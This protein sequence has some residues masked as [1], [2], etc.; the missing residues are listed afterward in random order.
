MSYTLACGDVMP[1]CPMTFTHQSQEELLGAVATHAAS[2][3]GIHEIT[4]SV[5]QAVTAAIRP[6]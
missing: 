6:A 4:P 1:G 3:H 2:G 5:L